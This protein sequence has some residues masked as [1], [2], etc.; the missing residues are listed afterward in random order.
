MYSRTIAFASVAA[1][2]AITTP[3]YGQETDLT[4][5]ASES[6]V[7]D[8]SQ[9]TPRPSVE[10]ISF[11]YTFLDTALQFMVMRMWPSTREGAK[12]PDNYLGSR[13]RWG[14]LS[15]YRLEGNRV[16]FSL[17]EEKDITPL[18]EYREDLER[19]GSEYDIAS[20]PR[21]EQLAYWMNLHNVAVIEQLAINYPVRSPSLKKFGPDQTSLDDAKVI[22]VAGVSLSPRDI[23]TRIVYPNWDNPN[24]IYGFFRGDIGGPS[25]Q[26]RAFTAENVDAAL[27]SVAS[28]F[29]NSLRGVEAL[30]GN[31][32]VSKI[33]E[34]AAPFYFPNM[35][36][37]LRAHLASH[38]AAD[39]SELLARNTQLS[40]GSY[41][42][43][44]ADL[45][46][47]ERDPIYLASVN[48]GVPPSVARL[49]Q[50][51]NEKIEKLLRDGELRGR[52]I[53]LPPGSDG[54]TPEEAAEEPQPE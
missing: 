1:L 46:G 11:D 12:R 50:E 28:E 31:V 34:E 3:A 43:T 26:K 49:L 10:A 44:I 35:A 27:P 40:V 13:M 38:A 14:H 47:G 18:T 51:R 42:D 48:A 19:L 45:A 17:L 15:R 25:I 52:V 23:R 32:K 29:V 6:A 41:E 4:V 2:A 7:S 37:D 21:G 39:V 16:V 54:S 33:Y 9:F 5:E 53:V 24:V 30:A 36:D 22:T 8:L 20:L